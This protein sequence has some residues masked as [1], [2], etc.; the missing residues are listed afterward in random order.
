MLFICGARELM[1]MVEII[2]KLGRV[3]RELLQRLGREAT[4]REL[5]AADRVED[6]VEATSPIALTVASGIPRIAGNGP[7]D[8]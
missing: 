7:A 4:A 2:N 1:D 6:D 5:A 3:E 8:G